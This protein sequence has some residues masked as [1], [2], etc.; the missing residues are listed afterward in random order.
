MLATGRLGH[1]STIDE[2]PGRHPDNNHLLIMDRR[3]A[4]RHFTGHLP[5]PIRL[6]YIHKFI[7]YY[8]FLIW[9]YLTHSFLPPHAAKF[10]TSRSTCR[11]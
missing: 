10:Q 11:K 4:Y 9:K 2:R 6:K 7:I 1:A 8:I 3:H 5:S